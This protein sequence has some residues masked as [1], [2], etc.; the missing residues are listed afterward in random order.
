M[1]KQAISVTLDEKNLLWLR[2]RVRTSARRSV[3]E[4]LDRLVTEVRTGL[5]PGASTV[6]SVVGTLRISESDP[7]LASADTAVR[8]K[9]PARARK[10]ARR[11][12]QTKASRGRRA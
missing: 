8:E 9:F 1:A 11:A 5:H 3:S 4:V 12:S 2:G 7:D 10:N 6:R